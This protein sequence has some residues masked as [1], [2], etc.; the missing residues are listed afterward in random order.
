M[1]FLLL[2]SLLHWLLKCCD[3]TFI[4]INHRLQSTPVG[5]LQTGH[6]VV[7]SP[8]RDR[9]QSTNR[10]SNQFFS[11]IVWDYLLLLYKFASLLKISFY[12]KKTRK[13]RKIY[14]KIVCIWK[15][16]LFYL[17]LIVHTNNIRVY[18]F[19][20]SLIFNNL[21]WLTQ[22]LYAVWYAAIFTFYESLLIWLTNAVF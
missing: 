19:F 2:L 11:L 10:V 16:T 12:W 4:P 18:I 9:H 5:S 14:I 20:C 17:I 22:F 7:V 21:A 8:N 1:F 3:I 6:E 13:R 15:K